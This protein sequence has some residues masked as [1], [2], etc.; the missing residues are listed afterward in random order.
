MRF[1]PRAGTGNPEIAWRSRSSTTSSAGSG[2]GSSRS[3]TS[4]CSNRSSLRDRGRVRR[5]SSSSSRIT[6]TVE[7]APQW[8]RPRSRPARSPHEL[9][10]RR[11]PCRRCGADRAQR[12]LP[13]RDCGETTDVVRASRSPQTR[14]ALVGPPRPVRQA[15]QFLLHWTAGAF[16]CVAL[17]NTRDALNG[18]GLL[19]SVV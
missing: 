15:R 9:D 4:R 12:H 2:T 14:Q 1:E 17:V 7:S 18:Q 8:C 3:P 10:T 13:Q 5:S 16:L 19:S 6:Q 11:A